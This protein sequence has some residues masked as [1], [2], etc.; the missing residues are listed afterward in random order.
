MA[1]KTKVAKKTAKKSAKSE[2]LI[3][4]ILDKSGSMGSIQDATISGF[5]EYVGTLRKDKNTN[6]SMSLTL[7]DTE[8][9]QRYSNTPLSKVADLSRENYRPD[10][11]TA[12]Y[13]AA[14]TTMADTAKSVEKNQKV[15]CVIMTDGEENSS[16]EYTDKEMKAKIKELEKTGHWSFVFLGA[17]QDSYL[18]GKKFGLSAQNVANFNATGA[19]AGM[20]MRTMATNTVMYAASANN[21]TADFFSKKDQ[22]DLEKTK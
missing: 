10:G 1:K 11:S 21:T 8:F 9:E 13:D 6:Y 20:V 2:T 4:F 22:D 3:V 7:F 12:L 15:L 16:K 14:C 5:N 17:N 18:V 19:S